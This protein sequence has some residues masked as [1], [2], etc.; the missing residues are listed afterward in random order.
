MTRISNIEISFEEQAKTKVMN[1]ERL[2]PYA[3]F[4]LADWPEG[5]EHWI[6]V[7]LSDDDEIL[8]WVHN[9]QN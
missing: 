7:L 5:T 3:D 2:K 6:W 1:D 9:C 8:D 4:I